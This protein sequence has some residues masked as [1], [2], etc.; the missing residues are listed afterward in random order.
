[1]FTLGTSVLRPGGGELPSE[2]LPG[3]GVV[4]DEH[5]DARRAHLELALDAFLVGVASGSGDEHLWGQQIGKL[6]AEAEQ[7]SWILWANPLFWGEDTE[8]QGGCVLCLRSKPSWAGAAI[9][10]QEWWGAF[11]V[12]WVC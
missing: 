10:L 4:E 12:P 11:Q 1:M 5:V 6:I 8:A 2:G 9:S 3:E 7:A